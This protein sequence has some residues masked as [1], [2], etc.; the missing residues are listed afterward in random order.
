MAHREEFYHQSQT[1]LDFIIK[2]QKD[3]GV[4]PTMREVVAHFSAIYGAG[5]NGLRSLFVVREK[6]YYLEERGCIVRS[7]RGSPRYTVVR[8]TVS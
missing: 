1:L 4:P 3:L 8:K 7:G 5:G 6:F 2:F